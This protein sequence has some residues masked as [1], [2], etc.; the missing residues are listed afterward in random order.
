[1]DPRTI[2]IALPA[3]V[4]ATATD[5]ANAAVDLVSKLD[6]W[7]SILAATWRLAFRSCWN[8]YDAILTASCL[9]KSNI[10]SVIYVRPHVSTFCASASS[11][12][13]LAI[14]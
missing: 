12:S 2:A 4:M 1:M 14:A 3:D 8:P 5:L 13:N 6:K 11:A 7:W 9:T 10:S